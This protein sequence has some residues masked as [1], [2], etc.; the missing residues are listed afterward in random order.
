[1]E[2]WQPLER[3][4]M[5][6]NNLPLNVQEQIGALEI[7]K[8]N[9]YTVFVR[10]YQKFDDHG[11]AFTWLSIK[12]N[13]KHPARDW[14]H[15]QWIKNQ[16]VGEENEGAELYPKESRLVD[17]SNQYH[18]WVLENKLESFPFGF[19]EGRTISETPLQG[20]RQRKWPENMKPADIEQQE[21]HVKQKMDEYNKKYGTNFQ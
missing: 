7:W 6:N 4:V 11:P 19:D 14:R 5:I 3:A 8:N 2:N 21:A 12:R 15:F 16:L 10:R 1:M 9:V 17:G 18:L 20:G 13:D